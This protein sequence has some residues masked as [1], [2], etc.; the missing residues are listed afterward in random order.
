MMIVHKFKEDGKEQVIKNR[1]FAF[2]AKTDATLD[3][4]EL[5]EGQRL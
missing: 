5:Y 1:L 4:A 2:L 3:E